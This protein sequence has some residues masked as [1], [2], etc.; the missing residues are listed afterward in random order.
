MQ[1]NHKLLD[2]KLLDIKL[3]N[4][5]LLDYKLLDIKLTGE[6]MITDEEF[7]QKIETVCSGFSGQLDDLYAVVGMMVVGRHYGWKVMRLVSRRGHWAM[8]TELFGDPKL[9]M[10]ERGRFWE[11][12]V[13]LKFVDSVGDYWAF[14]RGHKSIDTHQRKA[15]S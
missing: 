6:F 7:N 12:S 4:H 1:T 8:A 13:G 5:K 11:K 3:S 2:Y 14:I 10:L 15:V 9:L